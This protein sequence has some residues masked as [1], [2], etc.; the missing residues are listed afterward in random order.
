MSLNPTKIEWCDYTWNPI[1]G[2]SMNCPF[3]CYARDRV[4]PR[5]AHRCKLCGDF[6]PHMHPERLEEIER[7]RPTEHS[8]R[9]PWIANRFPDRFLIFVCSCADWVDPELDHNETDILLQHISENHQ[10]TFITLTKR[11]HMLSRYEHQIPANVWVGFSSSGERPAKINKK[12]HDLPVCNV[13]LMSLEP[14]IDRIYPDRLGEIDWKR[15]DWVIIGGLTGAGGRI[16]FAPP[17]EWIDD[18][19]IKCRQYGIAVFLK[20]N[21]EYPDVI[22]EFP[23]DE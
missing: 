12:I 8:S 3:G 5:Q 17:K 16:K 23:Y 18:I 4:A 6:V 14:Y 21:C 22:R 11:T 20:D 10:H 7:G 19:I 13:K 2:C 1:F 15:L 9:K